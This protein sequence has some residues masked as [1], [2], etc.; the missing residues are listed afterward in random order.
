MPRFKMLH[1]LH[2][3]LVIF[4]F[5]FFVFSDEIELS[6]EIIN[7]YKNEIS[8]DASLS[9]DLKNTID[10][11]LSD[12]LLSLQDYSKWKQQL[13]TLKEEIQNA[14]EEI[15]SIEE[16]LSSPEKVIQINTKDLT[17]EQINYNL[18]Q[19]ENEY[20]R[21]QNSYDTLQKELEGRN[22]YRKSLL[23]IISDIKQQIN[24][25]KESV[26]TDI[27]LDHP[28]LTK[29]KQL[30]ED[31]QI[32]SLEKELEY[33]NKELE[34]FDIKTRLI[35]SRVEKV[36]YELRQKEKEYE[37]WKSESNNKKQEEDEKNIRNSIDSFQSLT[38]TKTVFTNELL[39]FAS[40]NLTLARKRNEPGGIESKILSLN[41]NLKKYSDDYKKQ[42]NQL[43]NLR[44]KSKTNILSSGWAFTLRQE[45]SK[46]PNVRQLNKILNDL[47]NELISIEN[48]YNDLLSRRL[49]IS[50]IEN[51]IMS[52]F[53][54]STT[55]LSEYE[56]KNIKKS[57]DDLIKTQRNILS[58]LI[59]DY[60]IY[61][62]LLTE[63]ISTIKL[64]IEHTKE[65]N[66]YIDE[67]IIWIRSPFPRLEALKADA[68][69][70][71]SSLL[72]TDIYK[73]P[74]IIYNLILVFSSFFLGLII[75]IYIYKYCGKLLTHI[76]CNI[77]TP[78]Q[79]TY[80][81]LL[82]FI[83]C[84]FCRVSLL[85]LLF[86]VISILL[87]IL[88]PYYP[89]TN[90]ISISI[91]FLCLP[92]IWFGIIASMFHIPSLCEIFIKHYDK[93]YE[94]YYTKI[95]VFIFVSLILLFLISLS[96]QF[97]PDSAFADYFFRTIFSLFL[98]FTA[99][100]SMLSH[101]TLNN[102]I[103]NIKDENVNKLLIY[104]KHTLLVLSLICLVLVFL[105]LFGY[106]YGSLE[107]T[108]KIFASLFIITVVFIV[109]RFIDTSIKH[110][111]WKTVFDKSIISNITVQTTILNKE[112][113]S[114]N[115]SD[116]LT[117]TQEAFLLQIKKAIRFIAFI[118]G[119]ILIVY[120]WSDIFPALSYLDKVHI[121]SSSTISEV[122]NT[123]PSS[124]GKPS[125]NTLS[126]TSL[127]HD[128]VSLLDIL[129]S[130][131]IIVLTIIIVKNLSIYIDFLLSKYTKIQSGERYA[132]TT[133]LKYIV[134]TIGF[135]MAMGAIQITWNK[136][137]WLVAALGVGF[138]FGLQE[139]VAN[140]VS[141]LIL[142]FERPIRIGDI[143]TIGD[144][145]GRVKSLQMRSTTIVNWDNKEL[146]VPNKDL[147]TQQLINWTRN[148][149][150]VRLCIPIGVS[151]H[152]DINQVVSLLTEI[153]K[154]HPFVEHS[155]EPHVYFLRFGQSALEYELRVFTHIDYYLQLQHDL[156]SEIYTRFKQHNIEISYPQ[157]DVHIKN[158]NVPKDNNASQKET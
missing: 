42:K 16:Q 2:I 115:N 22:D 19:V 102:M 34:Y 10:K 141:G 138:G 62:S 155:P 26:S 104:I 14:P 28:T 118:T 25:L 66:T 154:T 32:K 130:F 5:S 6:P 81:R 24:N 146:I 33:H 139:I 122:I 41:D 43:D 31:T 111:Q 89:I 12:T 13:D 91:R 44:N 131:I 79:F 46:L 149:P 129:N 78:L 87:S 110:Y 37:F 120:I 119:F 96:S 15:K 153:A 142:L 107:L 84:F 121:W 151:Y 54:Q 70:L 92:L 51:Q 150:K 35:T 17:L 112:I 117:S 125:D 137:Q 56:K 99:F 71:F 38:K 101:K 158:G 144:I 58:S 95:V 7:N 135:I 67:N 45:K 109:C 123:P 134:F 60:D 1:M 9:Q 128:W 126:P 11:L 140:F 76:S 47:Q 39:T 73:K 132:I 36:K 18:L 82:L 75:V 80:R 94:K 52:V 105:N 114:N 30:F 116:N 157:L 53:L 147:L 85:P 63:T 113:E 55:N 143:V 106:N 57:I 93:E 74:Y 97:I 21:L 100:F 29:Y 27:S 68:T 124:T 77:N 133:V 64:W 86:F 49:K 50:D 88:F 72:K 20:N 59:S 40:E 156:L 61:I 127:T 90:N 136:I 69:N 48:D 108:K 23:L 148:E 103:D 4:V 145:S 8:Q 83:G 65:F 98:L 152:A 3:F